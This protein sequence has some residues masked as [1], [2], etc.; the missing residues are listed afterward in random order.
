M[1]VPVNYLAVLVAAVA[2]FAF[3]FLV[4]GPLLG[5]VWMGLMKITPADMEKG[6][7]EMEK[8][9]PLYM[10][11]AFVQQLVIAYVTALFVF[12][13]YA[14][15]V[16]D[17]LILTFWLWLGYIATIHLNTVLWEK[18]TLPLYGFNVA[19]QFCSLAI[20]AVILTLWQ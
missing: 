2:A 11:A 19:Y 16:V 17:A 1:D 13:S 9:M 5:K 7:K 4:H 18:R 3:G 15:N 12:M 10:G 8:K 20:V 6:K 14:T